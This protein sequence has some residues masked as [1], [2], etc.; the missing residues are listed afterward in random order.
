MTTLTELSAMRAYDEERP[1]IDSRLKQTAVQRQL[2]AQTQL[3]TAQTTLPHPNSVRFHENLPSAATKP[4]LNY[5]SSA[6]SNVSNLKNLFFQVSNIKARDETFFNSFRINICPSFKLLSMIS[7][8]S[9]IDITM[10]T[11]CL[12]YGGISNSEFL[13][14]KT[15]TLIKMGAKDPYLMRYEYQ[16]WRFITPVVLHT[17]LNHLLGNLIS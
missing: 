6:D 7:L 15:S 5:I 2:K 11:V 1:L 16:V 14:V 3:S 10:F 9:I 13:A 8:I 12:C 17:S 4:T